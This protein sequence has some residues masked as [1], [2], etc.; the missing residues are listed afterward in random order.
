MQSFKSCKFLEN[1]LYFSAVCRQ[2]KDVGLFH[3]RKL[4]CYSNENK[5]TELKGKLIAIIEPIVV[6][7]FS[8]FKSCE[9]DRSNPSNLSHPSNPSKHSNS[10][11]SSKPSN[12]TTP[13]NL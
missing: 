7:V 11:K 6:I 10:L 13:S 1:D 9:S 3:P 5:T 8:K 2:N 12:R 4:W